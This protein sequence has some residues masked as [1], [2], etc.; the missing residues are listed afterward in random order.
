MPNK[1]RCEVD[2]GNM[3]N[4]QA[5]DTA[6]E[7]AAGFIKTIG[8]VPLNVGR[9]GPSVSHTSEMIHA[10]I[11]TKASFGTFWRSRA[12]LPSATNS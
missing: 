4:A 5:R 2:S 12:Y 9:S 7:A 6:I 11:A 3:S 10:N 8:R 1:V